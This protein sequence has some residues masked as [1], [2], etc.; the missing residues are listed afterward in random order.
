MF[1]SGASKNVFLQLAPFLRLHETT[2]SRPVF[3][4]LNLNV[5]ISC[6]NS[7]LT[8]RGFCFS[9]HSDLSV[10]LSILGRNE[11]IARYIKLRTG[12]T[13]TRKQVSTDQQILTQIHSSVQVFV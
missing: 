8:L 11:L 5:A 7:P 9:A 3:H 12:K 4:M 10:A 2:V 1:F 6:N 13:R